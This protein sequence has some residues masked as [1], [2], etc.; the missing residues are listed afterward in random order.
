M[1]KDLPPIQI[2]QTVYVVSDLRAAVQHFND[3]YRIG[4]FL[5]VPAH[6]LKNVT[7]R[8]EPVHAE[9]ES[10]LALRALRGPSWTGAQRWP[11]TWGTNRSALKR[12]AR[13]WSAPR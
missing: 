2:I 6:P 5:H 10:T 8:G 12:R 11:R 4:P 1:T 9:V 7:H 3:I 13:S